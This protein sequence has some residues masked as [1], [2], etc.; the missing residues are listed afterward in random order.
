MADETYMEGPET[1]DDTLMDDPDLTQES[2]N[3]TPNPRRT[4]LIITCAVL[5][6][7][8]CGCIVVAGLLVWFDPFDWNLIA[9]ITGTYDA[10]AEAV[11]ADAD[12]YIGLDLLQ[13]QSADANRVFQAFAEA[14][15]DSQMSS[16]DEFMDSLDDEIADGGISFTEDIL[17]WVGQYVGVGIYDFQL[18]TNGEVDSADFVFAAAIRDRAAAE[19]FSIVLQQRITEEDGQAIQTGAYKGATI[20]FA[21]NFEND[22]IAFTIHRG[23]FLISTTQDNIHTSIDAMSGESFMDTEDFRKLSGELPDGALLTAFVRSSLLDSFNEAFS[24]GLV[25]GIGTSPSF[26][27]DAGAFSLSFVPEGLRLDT[28]TFFDQEV[29]S[30]VQQ[31]MINAFAEDVAI[32]AR[33]PQNTLLFMGGRRLDLNFAL[34]REQFQNA[35]QAADFDEAMNAF[36]SEFG[37]H[38]EDDLLVHLDGEY[39]I[40]LVPSSDG[41]LASNEVNLGLELLFETSNPAGLTMFMNGVEQFFSSELG[42]APE[43]IDVNGQVVH[44]VADPFIGEMLAYALTDDLL[45]LTTSAGLAGDVL[46]GG[47]S[48]RDNPSYQAAWASFPSGMRPAL[49]LDVDNLIGSIRE[50]FSEDARADFDDDIASLV[51]P[52][53]K[54]LM[55]NQFTGA[56]TQQATVIV[57]IEGGSQ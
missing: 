30:E 22:G 28:V 29:V 44:Q 50:G 21:P 42:V 1:E 32:D 55:G 43:P 49:Y 34:L 17:S 20:Y 8:S 6:L 26:L 3:G 36:A 18:A 23:M 54:I 7:V 48:L 27:W 41:F 11:P 46:S 4:T 24:S 9:R 52:I 35:D 10:A 45:I 57:F 51:G 37:F 12:I 56:N 38:P 13:L 39:A 15:P 33:V 40:A 53:S 5:A 2:E 14:N 47:S 25:S 31:Q 16:A 19:A